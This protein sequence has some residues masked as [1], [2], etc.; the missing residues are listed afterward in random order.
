[1]TF[2]LRWYLY[3]QMFFYHI[4]CIRGCP[5]PIKGICDQREKGLTIECILQ[6]RV[7]WWSIFQMQTS[8]VFVEK[9]KDFLKIMMFACTRGGELTQ[10]TFC[11]QVG[12]VFWQNCVNI[13]FWGPQPLTAW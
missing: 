2:I 5:V 6:T 1:M 10:W 3:F 12:G 7:D 4:K 11:G 9:R 8:E 13:F